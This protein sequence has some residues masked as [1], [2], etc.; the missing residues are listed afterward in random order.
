M[1]DKNTDYYKDQIDDNGPSYLFTLDYVSVYS[2]VL[3]AF[4]EKE[5]QHA[6]ESYDLLGDLDLCDAF[7]DMASNRHYMRCTRVSQLTQDFHV[8]DMRLDWLME[9]GIPFTVKVTVIE[10]LGDRIAPNPSFETA[11]YCQARCIF[12]VRIVDKKKASIF[13][14]FNR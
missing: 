14:L 12:Q 4:F 5:G 7:W 8:P 10:R 13:K 11:I 9:S 1:I 3:N 6:T 2:Y